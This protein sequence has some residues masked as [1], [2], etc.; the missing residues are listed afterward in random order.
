MKAIKYYNILLLL[1]ISGCMDVEH[2][3]ELVYSNNPWYENGLSYV[4]SN[5]VDLGLPSGIKW[6]SYNVGASAPEEFG[7]YY[8][9][10][11]TEEKSEYTWK[12]YKWCIGSENT[13]T[14]YCDDSR[15][16]I[17][18]YKTLLEP[19]DDVAHVK[20][21]GDWRM[22]TPAEQQELIDECTWV[23]TTLNGITGYE[24]TG[25]NGKSIFLPAAGCSLG[26]GV[27][28]RG[29]YGYYRSSSLDSYNFSYYASCLYFSSSEADW[30][31]SCYRCNGRTVRPVMGEP[32]I[33]PEEP[34]EEVDQGLPS[35]IKWATCNVGAYY[36]EDYGDYYA[37]GETETK[38]NYT[39]D[40]YKWCNG[41]K[42]TMTKYCTD[43]SYGIVDN[44]TVLEPED[45]VAHVKWGG[46]WRIPTRA[47]QDE[48]R[49]KCT[50][51]WTTLNDI[52]GYRVTGPNGKSIFLPAAGNR[53][54][55][56]VD[57]R[58]TRGYYWSSSLS[59][60]YSYNAY[61]LNGYGWHGYSRCIGYTVRPVS[62]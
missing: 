23:W 36:P 52:D 5:A 43:S 11:E 48:L 28:G 7:G 49:E 39:W 14:K 9:W 8:A 55:T 22:P 47:E 38:S 27:Y 31:Y 33:E 35:G 21:G 46:S 26:T 37:W 12:T 44:K 51:V 4:A 30:W 56:D 19:E 24:V 34:K 16:G 60:S 53:Y 25:P 57:N 3:Y 40:T 61:F 29:T 15:Y 45:D 58:G 1:L 6:A 2:E 17:V 18:D 54:G 42:Y 62:E 13:M 41:S 10:G 59:S 50:W 32:K 20:W